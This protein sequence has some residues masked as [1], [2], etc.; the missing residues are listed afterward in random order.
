METDRKR[1][2]TADYIGRMTSRGYKGRI[3]RDNR[4]PRNRKTRLDL[5]I[6]PIGYAPALNTPTAPLNPPNIPM[7]ST[8][9]PVGDNFDS[10]FPDDDIVPGSQTFGTLS[11][12]PIPST[13]PLDPTKPAIGPNVKDPYRLKIFDSAKANT[14]QGTVCN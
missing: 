3:V 2:I 13:K 9:N 14:T 4:K 6:A 10:G 1:V 8:I 12:F 7:T 11:A 5:T